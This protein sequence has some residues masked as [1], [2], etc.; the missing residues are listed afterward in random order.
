MSTVRAQDTESIYVIGYI[1][2]MPSEKDAGAALVRQLRE[3]SRKEAGNLRAEVGRR[4][5][6]PNEFVA[7]EAWSDQAAYDAHAQAASTTQLRDKLKAIQS[8][9]Y[10]E[11]PSTALSV[12]PVTSDSPTGGV[13]FVVTHIDV[14][15]PRKDEG[16]ALIKQHGDD[17]RNDSG[18]IRFE[19]VTQISRP[20]HFTAIEVWSDRESADNHAMNA[21]TRAFRD[22]LAPMCGALY[23]QRFYE[24]FD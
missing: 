12:G 10:D 17:S 21:H 20:N 16:A 2:V 24:A 5:G 14:V 1:E 15:P 19:L 22:K 11:R 6:Q 4:I 9:P 13:I 23:D 7:L 8:A 3:A 18:A